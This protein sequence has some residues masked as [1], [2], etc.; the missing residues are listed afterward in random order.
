MQYGV[1]GAP[2]VAVSA[3]QVGF[4]FAEWSVGDC[5]ALAKAGY[6]GRVSIEASIP[7]PDVALKAAL[8]LMHH[9]TETVRQ[10]SSNK[11]NP[12]EA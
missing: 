12:D 1:C 9:L 3:A 10:Q 8:L 11:R 7:E 6:D 2:P 5:A 4:T